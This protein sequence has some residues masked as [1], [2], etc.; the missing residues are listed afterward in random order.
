MITASVLRSCDSDG[1]GFISRGPWIL[2]FIIELNGSARNCSQQ[3]SN[4]VE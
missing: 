1:L 3:P 2:R 4:L